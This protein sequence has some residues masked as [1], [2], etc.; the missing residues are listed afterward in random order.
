MKLIRTVI[1]ACLL[2]SPAFGM[3][4]VILPP[5]AFRKPCPENLP[6][7]EFYY[8]DVARQCRDW[9]SPA[10]GRYEACTVFHNG[11][12]VFRIMPKVDG[13]N[14]TADYRRNLDMHECA[15]V[16]GWGPDHPGGSYAE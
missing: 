12:A 7:Y 4:A 8:W 3:G 6:V 16:N 15:H 14:I 13:M 10:E 5:E 2:T 1:I 11:K 9:G